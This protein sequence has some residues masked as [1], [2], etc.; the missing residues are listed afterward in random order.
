MDGYKGFVTCEWR[1]R[2]SSRERKVGKK[3]ERENVAAADWVL[4]FFGSN[5]NAAL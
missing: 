3:R 4:Y 5:V 1:E 2:K